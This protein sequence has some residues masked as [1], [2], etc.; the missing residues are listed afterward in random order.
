MMKDKVSD[1]QS[2]LLGLIGGVIPVP[3]EYTFIFA[4]RSDQMVACHEVDDLLFDF[5]KNQIVWFT[6][7]IESYNHLTEALDD[8]GMR[9]GMTVLLSMKLEERGELDDFYRNAS[10]VLRMKLQQTENELSRLR[11]EHENLKEAAAEMAS[12]LLEIDVD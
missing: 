9:W 4:V 2:K 7:Q 12:K 6:H 11:E 5:R 1:T 3:M 8:C 10:S